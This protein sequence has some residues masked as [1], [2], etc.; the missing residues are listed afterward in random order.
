ML[1]LPGV[2]NDEESNLAWPDIL[3]IVL[4]FAFVLGV[5]LWVRLSKKKIPSFLHTKICLPFLQASC[6]ATTD[7]AQGYFLAGRSSHWILVISLK[8]YTPYRDFYI[9]FY[10]FWICYFLDWSV[11]VCYEYWSSDVYR[12]GRFGSFIRNS[13][14]HV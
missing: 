12:F 6:K 8:N 4:Y 13:S 7:N 1:Q 2:Y 10:Y 14:G 5:G 3:I 9:E 11:N